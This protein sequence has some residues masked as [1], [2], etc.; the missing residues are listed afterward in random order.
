MKILLNLF[1]LLALSSITVHAQ[2]MTREESDQAWKNGIAQNAESCKEKPDAESA[3]VKHKGSHT[4]QSE[5]VI[6]ACDDTDK[7]V[8]ENMNQ[9]FEEDIPMLRDS[10]E[11]NLAGDDRVMA[12]A[13]LDNI[14][15][16]LNILKKRIL[17]MKTNE[18]IALLRPKI[19]DLTIIRDTLLTQND[20]AIGKMTVEE[21][22]KSIENGIETELGYL[23]GYQSKLVRTDS[24]YQK[25]EDLKTTLNV[26]IKNLVLDKKL[27]L[28]DRELRYV[29]GK[30]FSSDLLLSDKSGQ[31]MNATIVDSLGDTASIADSLAVVSVMESNDNVSQKIKEVVEQPAQTEEKSQVS[32]DKNE[33]KNVLLKFL[34]GPDN[35][36]ITEIQAAIKENEETITVLEEA[37]L[38]LS[39]ERLQGL[40][41]KQISL[42]KIKNIKLSSYVSDQ[43]S[44]FSLF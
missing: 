18:N 13:D 16:D 41:Q 36:S 33:S 15:Y 35:G 11:K 7:Y 29:S 31:V 21:W 14:L 25:L 2:E 12:L 43:E 10:S 23:E 17:A 32:I 20:V 28:A 27:L 26:T 1:V 30:L 34:F 38:Q 44:K 8:V 5:V 40:L 4:V 19:D 6:G 42:L 24:D 9:M 3:Y 39:D 22:R 37:K